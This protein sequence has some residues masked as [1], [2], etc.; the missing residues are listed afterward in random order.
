LELEAREK[1]RR[2]AEKEAEQMRWVWTDV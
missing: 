1:A 2:Q